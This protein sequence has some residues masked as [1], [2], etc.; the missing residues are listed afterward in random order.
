MEAKIGKRLLGSL[1]PD[2]KPFEVVDSEIKGF[3]LRIQPSG[4][5]TYYVTYRLPDGRRNRVRIGDASI[6][7]PVQARDRARELLAAV[8]Q[9]KDPAMEKQEARQNINLKTFLNETYLPWLLEHR[10]TKGA[11]V[12]VIKSAFKEF[13]N[14]PLCTITSWQIEKWRRARLEANTKPGTTNRHLTYLRAALTRA[15]DWGFLSEN[16]LKSVK[17]VRENPGRVRFL[18]MEER[19]RLMNAL[20]AREERLRSERDSHN[21]FCL[22]R[23]YKTLPNLRGFSFAD[24]LKPMVII[25]LNTGLRRGEM[26]QLEWADIDFNRALLTVRGENTK[27]NISRFIPLNVAAMDTLKQ[28]RLQC[29]S[30]SVLVFVNP[31]TG[32]RFDNIQTSWERVRNTAKL[33]DF[34]WHDLRHTFASEL[35]QRGVDLY[36]VKVL[37][38][39]STIAITERYAHLRPDNLSAAV[40][41]LDRAN[42]DNVVNAKDKRKQGGCRK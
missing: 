4:V 39:H 41:V 12:V 2:T 22:E 25:S 32:K 21:R 37:M 33:A 13:L 30:D 31:K 28:W 38:G 11:M 15:V 14:K 17:K 29:S 10:K 8:I 3:I 20:D 6:C 42:T 26:F 16:P 1:K 34:N 36:Q 7:M 19:T 40:A 24:Y 5:M 9:G 23:G 35:V 27:T 18:D